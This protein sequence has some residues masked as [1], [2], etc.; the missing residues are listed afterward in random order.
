MGSLDLAAGGRSDLAQVREQRG[1]LSVC[2]RTVVHGRHDARLRGEQRRCRRYDRDALEERLVVIEHFFERRGGVVA[3]VG[4][5]LAES[6]QAWD[7]QVL[8]VARATG[9]GKPVRSMRPGSDVVTRVT[10]GGW[11]AAPPHA[12]PLGGTPLLVIS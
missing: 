1:N 11:G 7:V 4:R 2:E 8:D 9:L 12:V 10:Q 3:E 5:G 6:A